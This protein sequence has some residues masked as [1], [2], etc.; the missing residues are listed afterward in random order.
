MTNAGIVPNGS[1][2]HNDFGGRVDQA[3]RSWLVVWETLPIGKS[4]A[5]EIGFVS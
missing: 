5:S 3:W 4:R 2:D 1:E